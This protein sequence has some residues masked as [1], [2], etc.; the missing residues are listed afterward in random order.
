MRKI[1]MVT[2][3]ILMMS[4]VVLAQEVET[5]ANGAGTVVVGVVTGHKYCMSNKTM[6]WW[7]AVSWCDGQDRRL[8]DLS[9]CGCSS[10]VNCANYK[11]PELAEEG[12]S[13]MLWTST[14][15]TSSHAYHIMPEYGGGYNMYNDY[16][17]RTQ[18]GH[19]RA[20]CY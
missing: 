14:P 13:R 19:I 15:R 1:L 20:L 16:N 17:H 2:C 8:F 6:N 10:T 12:N 7:N 3:G 5:C 4:S 11:C 18:S 9:D